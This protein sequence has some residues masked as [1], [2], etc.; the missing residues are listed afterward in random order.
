M[1]NILGFLF[2]KGSY[3]VKRQRIK[4][5]ING[6]K[7]Q[8]WYAR[9]MVHCGKGSVIMPA[10][11]LSPSHMELY[12][13]VVIFDRAR[14]EAVTKYV[15]ILYNPR[16]ILHDNVQIQQNLHLTCASKIEIGKN[17]AI[18]AN[19]TITDIHHQ[20]EDINLPIEQ[21]AIS[22]KDVFIGEDCKIYNNSV[23][24]PGTVIGKHCTV[25][26]NSVVNGTFP[27]FSVIV[28]SP[29]RI[30][31]RYSFEKQNW[32]KTDHKGNFLQL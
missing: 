17:T 5:I 14:I 13:R 15:G 8:C 9:F 2:R 32:L 28:G 16:I 6:L 23:I 4:H 26:A 11:Y 31:K 27:E 25:G 18:G 20:Y 10:F 22:I 1:N 29:A 12:N 19:V 24:L 30:V 7:T 3:H 21:Q